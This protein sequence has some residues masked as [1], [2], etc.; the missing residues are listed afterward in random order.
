MKKI[1]I[2]TEV[3]QIDSL[4]ELSP[5][6]RLLTEKSKEAVKNAYAPY[7]KFNV[8]AAVLL[9]NGEIF[10]GTNQENAAFPSGMC[11]ERVAMFYA[12]SQYPNIAVK[13]IAVSAF[14]NEKYTADPVPPCGACR[15]VLLETETRFKKPIKVLLV[16][17]EKITFTNNVKT[18]LPINFDEEF[19]K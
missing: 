5:K 3:Y 16:S 19:L 9:E 18:L 17:D 8:G 12:N 6:E 7:S 10:T 1:H 13:A 2:D 4:E 11:A 15:Q 14:Y